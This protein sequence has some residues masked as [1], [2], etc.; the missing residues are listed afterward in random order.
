MLIYCRYVID[1]KGIAA[2]VIKQYNMA[3]SFY[4]TGET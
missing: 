3:Q 2:E 4:R 1:F